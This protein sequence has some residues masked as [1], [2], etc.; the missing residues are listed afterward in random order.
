MF[1]GCVTL[2]KALGLSV[3]RHPGVSNGIEDQ[4]QRLWWGLSEFVHV[5]LWG[6]GPARRQESLSV[7]TLIGPLQT[8]R[9]LPLASS[10]GPDAGCSVASGAAG[11]EAG[12]AE[13]ACAQSRLRGHVHRG[14]PTWPQGLTA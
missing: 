9:H 10:V 12:S 4:P 14:P 8:N 13:A 1:P 3:P 5:K 6:Q 2:G 11:R 7:E